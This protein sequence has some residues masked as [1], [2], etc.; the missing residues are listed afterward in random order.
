MTEQEPSNIIPFPLQ[1]ARGEGISFPMTEEQAWHLHSEIDP[2]VDQLIANLEIEKRRRE[3][4]DAYM[5]R[6]IPETRQ[7][8]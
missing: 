6:T 5:M 2:M 3:L 4:A 7:R 8:E 1:E